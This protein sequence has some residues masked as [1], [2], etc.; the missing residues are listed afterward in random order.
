M[1]LSFNPE[2]IEEY[3][4]AHTTPLPGLLQELVAT[5]QRETGERSV[6][7]SG[8]I[9]GHLLQT[10]VF[11]SGARRVL[12]IGTFTGFSA[13][14][15]AAALPEEGRVVTCDINPETLGIARRFLARSPHGSKVEIR[16]GP[17]LETMA[18]LQG[19]FDLIFIDADKGNYTRYYEAALP[20]LAPR[21]LICV[22]NVLWSGRVLDPKSDDDRAIAA[23]N[24]N[25]R[26]DPRVTVVV[27]TVRDGVALIRR[28]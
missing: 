21:G 27:L 12:E 23:F 22:D 14:M 26:R 13:Q 11:V 1:T 24:D 15:M 9:E 25:V 3:A 28:L 16:E 8:Q 19:P 10:L 18:T 20:L 7:I 2:G 4:A 5:T 17:A 6:M